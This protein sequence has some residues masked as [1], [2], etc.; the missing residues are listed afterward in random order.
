[1]DLNLKLPS[2]IT[3][4]AVWAR[5][6]GV[7]ARPKVPHFAMHLGRRSNRRS[8]GKFDNVNFSRGFFFVN[9]ALYLFYLY[10]YS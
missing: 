5:F 3:L 1:V 4:T 7:V 2:S 6:S 9:S 8:G 10:F